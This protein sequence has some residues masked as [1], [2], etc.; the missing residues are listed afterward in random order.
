MIIEMAAN[1]INYCKKIVIC[2]SSQ[3]VRISYMYMPSTYILNLVMETLYEDNF[4]ADSSKH[5]CCIVESL[6][7]R[8]VHHAQC[9]QIFSCSS[10]QWCLPPFYLVLPQALDEHIKSPLSSSETPWKPMEDMPSKQVYWVH[11]Y[12]RRP[13]TYTLPG[14]L[15]PL[16]SLITLLYRL[17]F[18]VWE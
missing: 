13:Y 14:D 9:L 7:S 3:R 17:L 11:L 1:I 8:L 16:H 4:D 5:P 18:I 6:S 12:S 10:L 2:P 15:V